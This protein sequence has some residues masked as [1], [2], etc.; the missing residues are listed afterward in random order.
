MAIET[1]AWVADAIFYQIF[2]DRFATSGRFCQ[3]LR[4]EPWESPPTRFGF[5]G[6]DLI[7]VL[8]HLD[9]LQ[10]LGITAI[11]FNPIFASA[12][13]HRYH[14]YDYYTVDPLLGGNAAFRTLLDAA[15]RRRIRIILDGVF[16]HA[17]RGFWQFH[18]T[19]EN[20]AAS[21][22]VEW[23][24]FDPERL[25]GKRHFAAYP[26]P[27][28]RE[29]LRRG[30]G[31]YR[32]VGY[33]AWWDLPA[34]P[35]FNIA[36]PAVREFLWQ[37][38]T[39][40]V[41]FGIDG[42][43]LDVPTEINDD[44][45]WQEFRRRVKKVN[46]DAYLVGEIWHE[47][48]RWLR[49]DQ[50][51]AVMNYPLAK[52]CLGFFGGERLQLHELQR[53]GSYRDIRALT[54]VE[55]ADRI[56]ELLHLY[57]PAVTYAQLNLLDSHDTPRFLTSVGG[58][59]S[60]LQLAFLFLFTHPGAP[61]IY[62]GDEIGLTGRHDPDCR[63]TFPWDPARWDHD[64]LTFV[65]RCIALRHAHPA[66]RRGTY[67]RLYAD[68][69]VYVCGRTLATD[70]LII[71]FNTAAVVREITVPLD[72]LGLTTGAVRDVWSRE[73]WPLVNGTLTNLRLAPRSGLVLVPTSEMA[74]PI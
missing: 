23:F 15:H 37:V 26:D 18:H 56:D 73:C 8:D 64:I 17:S 1:P 51:D 40:W 62:Y 11:Y 58:D 34:L 29:A 13:N 44:S 48:Q 38:A 59:R 50:F 43:R 21:P 6:G 32:A 4:I 53:A 54:G 67:Q 41:E 61:C 42:W 36:T 39:H 25:S 70:T 22:Y 19:L 68:P 28:A 66:L 45:F 71:A 3:G 16:N 57:D 63:R 46:A 60:A 5:K 55:F 2:P 72:A 47:A 49:G 14:P 30:E 10:E 52:A 27:T 65:K 69:E 20:G 12:A 7:G 74:P 9:Y 35:K 24:H 33:K 31:S